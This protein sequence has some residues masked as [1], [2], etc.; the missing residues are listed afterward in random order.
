MSPTKSSEP[1]I[2]LV[3]DWLNQAGGAEVVLQV[4]HE[5]FP[6]A[7]IYTTIVD[8]TRVPEA[9]AW[10][11]RSTWMD[12]LP[13]IHANHQPY[14]PVYPL[15]W[16]TRRV[17][18]FD[19]VLSNKSG[20]CHGLRAPG[21]A[22]VCYCLTPT[23]YVWQ[24]QDYLAHESGTRGKRL[25]LRALLP[26][27]KRWDYSAAQ[28][29]DRFIGISSVVRERIQRYYDRESEVIFPPVE[30]Q[31]FQP[32]PGPQDYYLVL[33]RLVPYKRIDLAI[34]AFNRLGK[35]LVIVGDGRDRARLEA[36]SGPSIEFRGRLPQDEV[37]HMLA[38]CRA[39]I[40]P[41][42][43]DYGLVP[44][45]AMASGRPV[46][47][48]R[49]GGVLDTIVEGETGVFFGKT[50]REDEEPGESD[51][52]LIDALV[53]AI[54]RSEATTWSV[55][56]NRAQAARFGREAFEEKLRRSLE[57]ALE[58]KRNGLAGQTASERRVR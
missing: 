27:L 17:E 14:L 39:L 5:M 19:L 38:S 3:H 24:P 9:E 43:E 35:R 51:A 4:L 23:R 34:Q 11:V 44:V 54:Q 47:A 25:A 20:F 45:E 48:R 37:D 58:Q 29:V 28:R 10:D 2:A 26:A 40:W 31:R 18:G 56:A 16:S 52:A 57:E 33:A 36:M 32:L 21:A 55:E 22:H 41:G 30:I 49:A 50:H 1:K 42:I 53:D 12:R 6:A 15:A 7:P 8:P 46:I 13:G